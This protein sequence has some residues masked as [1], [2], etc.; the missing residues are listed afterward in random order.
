MKIAAVNQVEAL[1]ESTGLVAVKVVKSNQIR[2]VFLK[3]K[4]QPA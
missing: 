4:I 2:N 1:V 3:F